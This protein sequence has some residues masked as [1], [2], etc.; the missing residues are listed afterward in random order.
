MQPRVMPEEPSLGV[1]HKFKKGI[2][3]GVVF[4]AL[5]LSVIL[6]FIPQYRFFYVPEELPLYTIR[7]T[8]QDDTL[9]IA[10]IGDSWADYHTLLSGDTIIVNAGKRIYDKPVKAMTRG[11][12]GALSK[13]IYYFMYSD[14]TVEHSNEPDRCTQPLIEAHPDYCVVFA[15]INDVTYL[16]PLSYYAENM[17]LIIRLLLHNKIRPVVMEIP[18]VE[19]TEPMGRKIFRE[20]VFFR[21]R[22]VL[23]GT[24]NNQG[25]DYQNA[26]KDMLAKTKLQD[27]VLYISAK[28][29]NPAGATDTTMFLT[30]RLHLNLNGYHRLD[31]CI[32]SKIIRDHVTRQ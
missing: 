29:W 1:F 14:M 21:V 20:R 27:S 19:F 4:V 5:L 15:G 25:A 28:Q 6:Y 8:Y 24:D 32:I 12:K 3:W 23:M 13:E 18:I 7:K 9:R 17:R 30:D 10:F 31:S 22:A 11:K 26:L 2:L 16:R